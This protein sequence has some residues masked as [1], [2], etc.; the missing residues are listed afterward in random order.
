MSF[1]KED[2]NKSLSY[3]GED[4]K[5]INLSEVFKMLPELA[6]K[7]ADLAV[8]FEGIQIRS[9]ERKWAGVPGLED[10]KEKFS[11]FKAIYAI[12]TGDWSQAQFEADVFRQTRDMATTP[13][14][15]GGYLVPTQA[16][17]ELIAVEW[18]TEELQNQHGI[19]TYFED[20]HQPKPL[21]EDLR[22]LIFQ[23][24]NELD[25]LS[26]NHARHPGLR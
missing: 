24:V 16:I 23:A 26:P 11:L 13:D 19:P 17:P 22:V 20:D 1:L 18:L 14:S 2:V 25:D 6:A 5:V 3:T 9:R 12:G 21:D 10:E 7:H 4:G 8:R 15:S